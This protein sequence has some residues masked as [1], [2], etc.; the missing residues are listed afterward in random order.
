MTFPR[1]LHNAT[2]T[3]VDR[4]QQAVL[5]V[6]WTE[7]DP[8]HVVLAVTVGATG[9]HTAARVTRDLL[10]YGGMHDGLSVVADDHAVYVEW[11]GTGPVAIDHTWLSNLLD[12]TYDMTPAEAEWDRTR[13]ELNR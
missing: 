8:A 9:R 3:S 6:T 5:A 2:T 7:G 1:M 11:P 4:G 10:T 13:W 12:A